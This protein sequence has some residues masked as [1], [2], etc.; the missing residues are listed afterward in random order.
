MQAEWW[1]WIVGGFILTL[2]E[3]I[4]P[5]F[6]ILWFG[7]VALLVGVLLI[8]L[9]T[10]TLTAQIGL[11]IL[12]SLVMVWAWFAYFRRDGIRTRSGTA[13]GQ[14][15][16]EIGLLVAGTAPFGKGKVR[17]QRPVMGN[18]EWTC[19]ADESIPAGARVQVT[20]IEGNFLRVRKT[21]A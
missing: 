18:D 20:A 12:G 5:T 1:H 8:F 6:F 4:I 11:W 15:L 14:A 2:A 19:L 3:L 13:D 7:I 10:I 9:P 21:G 16:G 17:F